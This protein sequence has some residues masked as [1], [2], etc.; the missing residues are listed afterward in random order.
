MKRINVRLAVLMAAIMMTM[1]SFAKTQDWG[2]RVL[3]EKG[4]AMPRFTS[5]AER[6]RT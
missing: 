3:D 5:M 4:V 6:C 1:M 2:G